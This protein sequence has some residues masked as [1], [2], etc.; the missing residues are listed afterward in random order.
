M[1]TKTINIMNNRFTFSQLRSE[2]VSN[3]ASQLSESDH[4]IIES[5]YDWHHAQ[6]DDLADLMVS[7]L[8]GSDYYAVMHRNPLATIR[9]DFRGS[10]QILNVSAYLA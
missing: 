7:V 10:H 3:F 9:F 6:L 8:I 1:N 4:L 5:D 2:V